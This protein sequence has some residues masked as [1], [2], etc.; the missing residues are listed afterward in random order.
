MIKKF[1]QN[2]VRF[3]QGNVFDPQFLL[4]KHQYDVIFC[5][6]LLIYLDKE[7]QNNLSKI[8]DRLLCPNGILIIGPAESEC[9]RNLGYIPVP[10][11][12]SFAFYKMPHEKEIAPIMNLKRIPLTSKPEKSLLAEPLPTTETAS[13]EKARRLADKGQFEEAESICHEFLEK[14]G[15]DSQGFFLLGLIQHATGHEMLAEDFFLKTVYLQPNHYEAL[16]YL[17]LLAEKKGDRQQAELFRNRAERAV[18]G[19]QGKKRLMYET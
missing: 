8:L 10:M 1:I 13:L 11:P 3:Q 12:R 19:W 7:S 4:Q 18:S 15:A 9:V 2:K 16:V 14:Y 6:N 17:S 5:R